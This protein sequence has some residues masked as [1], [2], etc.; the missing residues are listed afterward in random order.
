MS[1]LFV[2]PEDS[3][4]FVIDKDEKIP[5]ASNL[6][7]VVVTAG[8]VKATDSAGNE[9]K[10]SD[11]TCPTPA[12]LI[13]LR[14]DTEVT[15]CYGPKKQVPDLAHRLVEALRVFQ[16]LPICLERGKV[17]HEG[18]V[19]SFEVGYFNIGRKQCPRIAVNIATEAGVLTHEVFTRRFTNC[20]PSNFKRRFWKYAWI[21]F[22]NEWL[23][24]EKL[25]P[26]KVRSFR[27]RAAVESC[28]ETLN[29][30]KPCP[31]ID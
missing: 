15:L 1:V 13:G 23:S 14:D 10:V 18:T 6:S 27:D 21:K 28:I 8:Q 2:T 11:W 26:Q 4:T 25:V 16:G 29:E 17:L 9:C 20:L 24:L 19:G 30:F 22:N 7:C 3:E 5:V 31:I 12:F